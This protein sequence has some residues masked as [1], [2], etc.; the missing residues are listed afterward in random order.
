MN[1]N[2]PKRNSSILNFFKKSDG[3]VTCPRTQ[4]RITE[5][6][7]SSPSNNSQG[8]GRNGVS[9]PVRDDDGSLFVEDVS[10]DTL[11]SNDPP[12][13][14]ERSKTPDDF[15]EESPS[16]L[17]TVRDE[18]RYNENEG[19][20][21]KKRKVSHGGGD[22]GE[23]SLS[24]TNEPNS[25]SKEKVSQKAKK[26]HGPF[27]DDS[28]SED[29]LDIIRRDVFPV[30]VG[31]TEIKNDDTRAKSSIGNAPTTNKENLATVLDTDQ[32][33]ERDSAPTE[34]KGSIELDSKGGSLPLDSR[35]V[36]RAEPDATK[37]EILEN[38][39]GD[40]AIQVP[41]DDVDAYD[42]GR[43]DMDSCADIPDEE[44]PA[45]P[46]CQASLGNI[47][48]M[49]SSLFPPFCPSYSYD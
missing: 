4:S 30:P 43:F 1:R 3:P 8:S 18:D 24:T 19:Y 36:S 45:C 9:R 12:L 29:E 16:G 23:W 21:V 2:K 39:V 32:L 35:E 7:N 17:G 11:R 41:A 48:D 15:W 31:N 25:L 49:V 20:G 27:I 10:T 28:D 26:R 22:T 46:I 44:T 42:F 38:E 13:A 6:G 14:R 40:E 33:K 47:S 5:F 34:S 37:N